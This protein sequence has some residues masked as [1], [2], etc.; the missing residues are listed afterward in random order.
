MLLAESFIN[1]KMLC[2]EVQ[3]PFMVGEQSYT[4]F[5]MST[6]TEDLMPSQ[7]LSTLD[8]A[9]P[10]IPA[11]ALRWVFT[12]CAVFAPMLLVAYSFAI[13]PDAAHRAHLIVQG[14]ES[15]VFA[16]VATLVLGAYH[17]FAVKSDP[18]HLIA[19]SSSVRVT[20]TA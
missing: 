17:G 18:L 2:V 20:T 16:L 9:A 15:I 6:F 12:V 7:T 11:H 1:N 19:E 13:F 8:S 14:L 10:R 5:H 4:V 3:I